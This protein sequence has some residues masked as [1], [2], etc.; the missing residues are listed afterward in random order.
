MSLRDL[1]VTCGNRKQEWRD[2][3]ILPF[4]K[5]P[6]THPTFETF[7]TRAWLE[8]FTLSLHNFLNTVFHNLPLPTLLSFDDDQIRLRMMGE[9]VE[10]LR[11]SVWQDHNRKAARGGGTAAAHGVGTTT[12]AARG[13]ALPPPYDSDEPPTPHPAEHGGQWLCL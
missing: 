6:E 1:F 2:W 11:A 12:M 9:E 3:F 13:A 4:V 10:S 8:T 5:N 7:F